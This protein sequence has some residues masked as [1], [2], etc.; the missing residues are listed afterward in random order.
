MAEYN[1]LLFIGCKTVTEICS[2]FLSLPLFL[3]YLYPRLL[4]KCRHNPSSA[5]SVR[6]YASTA[7]L[8]VQTEASFEV[9]PFL[10][11]LSDSASQKHTDSPCSFSQSS[12]AC[13]SRRGRGPRQGVGTGSGS[14]W[15]PCRSGR[16]LHLVAPLPASY[17][18]RVGT[19]AAAVRPLMQ[20]TASDPRP[21]RLLRSP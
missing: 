15:Q 13:R 21:P 8:P 20:G 4:L 5:G 2:T 1:Q 18:F 11:S 7:P 3:S 9:H 14:G 19:Q 12:S 16:A 10:L 17:C 6:F